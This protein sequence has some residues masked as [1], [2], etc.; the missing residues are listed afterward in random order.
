MEKI[1]DEQ[2]HWEAVR[3]EHCI[4]LA[5][6]LDK[7]EGSKKF[8]GLITADTIEVEPYMMMFSC[9]L[10]IYDHENSKNIDEFLDCYSYCRSKSLKELNED[11]YI[12]VKK[13]I[14]DFKD[15]LKLC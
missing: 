14:N 13:F 11:D 9:L 1:K 10:K 8:G 15:I 12:D 6:N 3:I 4:H 2:I 5:L 7:I